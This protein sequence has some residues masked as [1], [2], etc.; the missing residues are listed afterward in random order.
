MEIALVC[1]KI[2]LARVT[3]VSLGTMRTILIVRG[4]KIK[5]AVIA[6]FEV[7]IWFLIAKEAL[8]TN[9]NSILIPIFYA[10]GYSC[11]TLLGSTISNKFIDSLIGVQVI[12]KE[13]YSV[14]MIE[15]IRKNGFGVSA[16]ELKNTH[17]DTKKDM[18]IIELNRSKLKDLTKII[19]SIDAT[20]FVII[21]DTK[22][23]QNGLMK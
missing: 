12:T 16:L 10:G 3:D 7:F 20:A 1:L 13:M 11:G 8:N 4:E 17:D 9:I 6:F 18:L 22:Y 5:G 23:I 14:S 19:R 15:E 2:F 21:N